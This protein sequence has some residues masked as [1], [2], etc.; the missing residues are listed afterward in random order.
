MTAINPATMPPNQA[1]PM[2][3]PKNRNTNGYAITCCS[4]NVH[5]SATRTNTTAIATGCQDM[6]YEPFRYSFSGRGGHERIIKRQYEER[7][8]PVVAR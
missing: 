3:A 2:I 6:L 1:L 8:T 7:S 5:R 4:R